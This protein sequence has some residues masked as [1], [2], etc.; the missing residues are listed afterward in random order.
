MQS[1]GE[2]VSERER[3]L[4]CEAV[5]RAAGAFMMFVGQGD[6]PQVGLSS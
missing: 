2:S 4:C 5:Y 1:I 6:V 3:S